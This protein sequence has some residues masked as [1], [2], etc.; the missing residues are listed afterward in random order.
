A[1]QLGPVEASIRG[2]VQ[3][4]AGAAAVVSENRSPVLIRRR[5]ENVGALPVDGNVRDPGV[6]VHEEG[7][8]PGGATVGAHVHATLFVGSPQVAQCRHVNNVR[9]RGVDYD[10]ADMV[11]LLQAHVGK[12]GS[13]VH[14]LI[15]TVP[16][17]G[18]L[19]VVGF[20]GAHVKDGGVGR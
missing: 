12:G 8:L 15:Y 9:I 13:R 20:A 14:R 6:F 1:P 11:R 3:T 17:G 10:A 2:P 16:P 5:I 18:T 4:A 19:T 7:L